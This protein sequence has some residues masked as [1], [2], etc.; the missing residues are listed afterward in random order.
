[1][2]KRFCIF[3]MDGT[4]VDSMGYWR[5]LGREYL[6]KKGISEERTD[7]VLEELQVMSIPKAAVV[8]RQILGM[9]LTEE[10]LIE[11]MQDL[12][13]CHYQNDVLLKP[14]ILEYLEKLKGKNCRMCVATATHQRLAR[15]CLKHLGID[16]YF[17]FVLSCKMLGV[18]KDKPDVYL[19]AAQQLGSRP[20]ETAVFE[21][22]LYAAQTAKS[23]GFY[24]VAVWDQNA[25]HEWDSLLALADEAV[26]DWR[27]AE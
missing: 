15:G 22:V 12:M 7:Q 4:L 17:E 1:M 16:Q 19:H 8:F 27:E 14:G 5:Q 26:E 6:L 25:A 11:E 13:E 18:G 10:E 3:D 9:S 21:D 2:D 20:E 24:T 23:A